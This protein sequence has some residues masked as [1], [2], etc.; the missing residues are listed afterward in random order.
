MMPTHSAENVRELAARLRRAVDL[1]QGEYEQ[2]R[3][4]IGAGAEFLQ[5]AVA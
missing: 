3:A 2:Y 1:T 4:R 5:A